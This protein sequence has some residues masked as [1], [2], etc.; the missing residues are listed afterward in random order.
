M[1]PGIMYRCTRTQQLARHR[2]GYLCN[3]TATVAELATMRLQN[4]YRW[5][6]PRCPTMLTL[7]SL[8]NLRKTCCRMP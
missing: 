7:T 5:V 6:S 3:Q 4:F 1:P 2:G 8:D